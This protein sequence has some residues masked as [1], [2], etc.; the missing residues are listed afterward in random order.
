MC[1]TESHTKIDRKF[2]ARQLGLSDNSHKTLNS[3]STMTTSLANLG[4]IEIKIQTRTDKNEK[5]DIIYKTVNS[6]R[7]TTLDEYKEAKKRGK[8]K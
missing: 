2:L 3:I 8:I 5:G 6:Y 7:L 4:F 1:D